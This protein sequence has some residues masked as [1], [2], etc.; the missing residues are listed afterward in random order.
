MMRFGFFLQ[1]CVKE[2]ASGMKWSSHQTWPIET[3]EEKPK[4]E[5]QAVLYLVHG[6]LA[7]I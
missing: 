2:V 3:Q 1:T 4:E 5:K 6:F 7:S